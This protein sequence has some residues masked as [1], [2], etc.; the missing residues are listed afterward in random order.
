MSFDPLAPGYAFSLLDHPAVFALMTDFEPIDWNAGRS[1]DP[2]RPPVEPEVQGR[3]AADQGL[4]RAAS[5]ATLAANP[6]SAG[7]R[8]GPRPD[9]RRELELRRDRQDIDKKN[10][11]LG[12][13][14]L[15]PLSVQTQDSCANGG[16]TGFSNR[17]K[18]LIDQYKFKSSARREA[19][20]QEAEDH[21]PAQDEEAGR[22]SLSNLGAPDL[23]QQ[24]AEPERRHGD[25]QDLG[26]DRRGLHRAGLKRGGGAFFF[27]ASDDSMRLLFQQPRMAS[28]RPPT[29]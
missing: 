15:G 18:T 13:P 4:G 7:K 21:G 6:L 5:P 12:G 9:R 26:G 22:P 2:G 3:A 11:R 16:P 23:L 25:H 10:R 1:T 17:A 24:H 20:G 19:Q 29:S 27:F 28:L 8:S 14:H